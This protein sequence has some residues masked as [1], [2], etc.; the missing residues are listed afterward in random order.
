MILKKIDILLDKLVKMKA[1]PD[2]FTHFNPPANELKTIIFEKMNQIYLPD[3]FKK[4]LKLFNGGMMVFDY[5]DE[6]LQTQAD[7]DMYK[8]DSVYLLSID[9]LEKKYAHM[10]T[11]ALQRGNRNMH[12]YPF[13]PF[14]TLPDHTFLLFVTKPDSVIESPV[15]L[16]CHNKSEK[17]WGMIAPDFASFF[18]L[19]LHHL[20]HPPIVEDQNEV[21]TDFFEL[22]V[23]NQRITEFIKTNKQNLLNLKEQAFNF[24]QQAL[25]FRRQD[26]FLNAYFFISKA[27]KITADDAFYYFFRGEI[28]KEVKK[29]RAAIIDYDIAVKLDSTNS[30]YVCCRAEIFVL[31]KQFD[32]AISDCNLAINIYSKSILPY[33][34]RKDI[35]L[36]LGEINKAEADQKTIDILE[37]KE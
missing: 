1:S 34:L 33:Y 11:L 22:L 2:Y 10:C 18:E 37:N 4:F 16:G 29:Y 24:Y 7:F 9:E 5:Q 21:G 8:K 30:F 14:C 35:Y 19:Y 32:K 27:I 3:S 25:D 12:P 36:T 13:I 17:T 20:G 28:L 6:F 31:M 26:D 23:K 15:F